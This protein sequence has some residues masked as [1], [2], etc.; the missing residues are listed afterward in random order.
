MELKTVALIM[1]LGIL[2]VVVFNCMGPSI[3][4]SFALH[5]YSQMTESGIPE[6]ICLTIY[7]VDPGLLTRYPWSV[8]DLVGADCVRIVNVSY[9]QIEKHSAL[10]GKLDASILLPAKENRYLDARLYYVFETDRGR[11][12]EVAISDIGGNVFVNGIEVAHDPV[13]YDILVPFLSEEDRSM[14]GI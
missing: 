13:F 1:V 3:G 12:L 11:L 7:F 2:F 6:D 10:L 4:I 14:L 8:D 9:N 5:E